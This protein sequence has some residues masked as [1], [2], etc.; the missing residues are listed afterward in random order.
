MGTRRARTGL[1]CRSRD[2]PRLIAVWPEEIADATTAGQER[3]IA[4]LRRALREERRR[5]LAGHWAY[6]LARHSALYE[7]YRAEI[8]NCRR[9]IANPVRDAMKVE[10]GADG[11]RA[12]KH[13]PRQ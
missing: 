8:S 13:S 1:Y 4:K 9:K 11:R 6:D 2:L 10:G 3:L 7:A 5:G 12:T